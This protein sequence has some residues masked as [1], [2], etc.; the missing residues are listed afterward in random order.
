MAEHMAEVLK[1]H[2]GVFRTFEI[3]GALKTDT[4][5]RTGIIESIVPV[6]GKT[7]LDV[8]AADGFESRALA[9][10]G[11]ARALAVE[12][13]ESLYVQAR[14]AADLLGLDNHDVL[15][16]DVRVID[17]LGL[18]T[19][20]C[21]L[22]FGFLYHMSNSFNVLKRLAHVTNGLL[23]LETHIAPE[24]WAKR[25][26]KDKLRGVHLAGVKTLY[27]DNERFE[28]RVC[29]HRGDQAH[30]KGSLDENWTFWLTAASLVKALTRAGFCIEAW[31]HEPDPHT[32]PIIAR[33]GGM[34]GF[35]HA[36]TKVFVVARVDPA[37]LPSISPAEISSEPHALVR[38]RFA[39]TP[40]D[41][42]NRMALSARSRLKGLLRR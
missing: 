3:D 8:G 16:A 40:A 36:N 32:P 38:P 4:T 10:R 41:L 23:L 11:A 17:E 30:S 34:L 7:F 42:L 22:C 26:L 13:K 6:A 39:K 9:L 27:L 31:H 20:D 5:Y 28:G 25:L 21:V 33:Y 24:P 2:P 35:G 1:A 12:G 18:G 19:F 15:K 37:R 29:M 14:K